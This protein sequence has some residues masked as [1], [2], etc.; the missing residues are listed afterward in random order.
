[1]DRIKINIDIRNKVQSGADEF[2]RKYNQKSSRR[3]VEFE[4]DID[5]LRII[6]NDQRLVLLELEA[7]RQNQPA[8]SDRDLKKAFVDFTEYQ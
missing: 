8:Y 4:K 5:K 6:M 1:M 2:A 7:Y 3:T